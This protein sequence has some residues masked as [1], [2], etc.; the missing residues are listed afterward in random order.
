MT[1]TQKA[2][3]GISGSATTD[4]N[5]FGV[6]VYMPRADALALAAEH[7][8]EL[9][10]SRKVEAD[11]YSADLGGMM[12]YGDDHN[13]DATGAACEAPPDDYIAVYSIGGV[14]EDARRWVEGSGYQYG[15]STTADVSAF[16]GEY[17]EDNE[18]TDVV[19]AL[20]ARWL[21]WA[22]EKYTIESD[23]DDDDEDEDEDD[24]S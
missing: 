17:D 1:A 6:T 9:D 14:P 8:V 3:V 13:F 12:S 21:E 18:A 24:A 5:W 16:V 2:I 11:W 4:E 7:G 19:G 23:D 15:R 20:A 10:T 22:D